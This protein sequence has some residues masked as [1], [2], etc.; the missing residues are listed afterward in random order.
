MKLI[1]AATTAPLGSENHFSAPTMAEVKIPPFIRKIYKKMSQAMQQDDLHT[2]L[3]FLRT[4]RTIH[5]L[6]P[7]T[8]GKNA[9]LTHYMA[10]FIVNKLTAFLCHLYKQNYANNSV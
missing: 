5:W 2:S 8:H 9:L 10:G 6:E 1:C 7:V 3:K 4:I